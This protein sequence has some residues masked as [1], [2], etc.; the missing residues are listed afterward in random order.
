VSGQEQRE[1]A[2]AAVVTIA[3]THAPHAGPRKLNEKGT[4]IP[5]PASVAR[6]EEEEANDA[7]A[8]HHRYE[9]NLIF[10][11]SRAP[12]PPPMSNSLTP[13]SRPA[14]GRAALER[15][16]AVAASGAPILGGG[17][18]TGLSAAGLD[19]GGAD[20]L[21]VYNSGRFRMAGRGSL[22]GLMPYVR[23]P[24]WGGGALTRR[25]ATR[26]TSCARWC[27]RCCPSSGARRCSR[28]C[29]RRTRS[30]TSRSSCASCVTWASSA[31][32]CAARAA[33]PPSVRLP[34]TQN[35]P[36]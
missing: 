14:D 15:L 23:A 17:A 16:R 5:A 6:S 3:P 13:H 28:V 33:A 22:A 8:P 35:F 25:R 19:A 21:V 29:A 10:Y 34:L 18:G 27:A 2:A 12:P 9:S 7:R 24:P 11:R 32:R 20:L 30:G 26:T 1:D 31:S 4:C 36:T